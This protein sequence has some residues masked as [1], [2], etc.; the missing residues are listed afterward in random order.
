MRSTSA[1]PERIRGSPGG[2]AG[3]GA[4]RLETAAQLTRRSA[5]AQ[6][7][8]PRP[9]IATSRPGPASRRSFPRPPRM[10]S[11]PFSRTGPVSSSYGATT[12]LPAPPTITSATVGAG[13]GVVAGLAEEPIAVPA[14]E[15]EV[16]ART[17]HA[18][19]A[20]GGVVGGVPGD[21]GVV[22]GC[23]RR[24]GRA[25]TLLGRGHCP[26]RRRRRRRPRDR[27][28]RRRPAP[29]TTDRHR[30]RCVR[31]R[32]PRRR[33][34][35]RLRRARRGRVRRRSGLPPPSRRGRRPRHVRRSRRC[36]K[37]PG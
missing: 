37:V 17:A 23:R 16:V 5:W 15:Q 35:R 6:V 36:R 9:P 2:G 7:S 26:G 31:P 13:E 33:G 18:E 22:A 1:R 27:R 21:H 19:V 3:A 10:R 8:V 12:S 4:R 24:H 11:L 32:Q 34:R 30:P 29:R 28:G 20:P 14:A 25:R